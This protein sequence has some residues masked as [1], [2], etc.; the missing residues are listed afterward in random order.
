[1]ALPGLLAS[2]IGTLIFVGLI[3][4]PAWAASLAP[5][6]VPPRGGSHRRHDRLG[7]GRGWSVPSRRVIRWI[8]YP[9]PGRASDRVLVTA[10]WACVLIGLFA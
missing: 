6:V 1:V 4:S 7:A 9:A 3:P 5:T 2:G 10:A 8:G